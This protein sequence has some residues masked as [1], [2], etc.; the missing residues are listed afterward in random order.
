MEK[1]ADIHRK[2]VYCLTAL[3]L[4]AYQ[5]YLDIVKYLVEKGTDIHAK[6]EE[7]CTALELAREKHYR[8]V[9]AY[10]K[11]KALNKTR[12][13]LYLSLGDALRFMWR[14]CKRGF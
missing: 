7:G 1:G 9:V 6:D 10:L 13:H 11:K 5:G 8:D 4:S 3:H 14:F 2:N 12:L